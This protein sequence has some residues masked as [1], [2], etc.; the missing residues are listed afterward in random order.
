MKQSTSST[1]TLRKP[2]KEYPFKLD[3]F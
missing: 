2:A 3:T 1:L